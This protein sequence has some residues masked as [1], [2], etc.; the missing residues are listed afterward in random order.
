MSIKIPPEEYNP[1]SLK[2]E[3]P[4]EIKERIPEKFYQNLRNEIICVFGKDA[5][6]RFDNLE[7]FSFSDYII[8]TF[9]MECAI[10][11]VCKKLGLDWLF[12]YYDS[13]DWYQSDQ[14]DSEMIEGV[15]KI[16]GIS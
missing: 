7:E 8:G 11:A 12:E 15:K 13:L 10:K 6:D 5:F 1:F 2:Y 16:D 4:E 9:G 14:F 3:I